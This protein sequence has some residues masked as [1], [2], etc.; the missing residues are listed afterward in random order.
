[1]HSCDLN[2]PLLARHAQNVALIHLPIALFLISVMFDVV[3]HWTKN[4][5]LAAVAYYNLLAAAISCVPILATGILAW[6][7]QLEGEWLKGILL[8]H[9]LLALV[10]CTLIW[11]VSWLQLRDHR[12][13]GLAI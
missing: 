11:L 9:V 8:Q 4:G 10:Y 1:V 13:P 2:S 7:W 3:A 5:V 6:L 12:N